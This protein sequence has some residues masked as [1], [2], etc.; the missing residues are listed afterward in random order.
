[1][2]DA[3]YDAAMGAVRPWHVAVLLCGALSCA[4]IVAGVVLLVTK[5]N[6]RR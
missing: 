1:M 4:A 6:R 2:H 5:L 3:A